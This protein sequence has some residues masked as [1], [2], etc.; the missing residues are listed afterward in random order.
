[1]GIEG[2]NLVN[3]LKWETFRQN[4]AETRDANGRLMEDNSSFF[5]LINKVDYT[6]GLGRLDLQPRFKSELLRQTAFLVAE[7]DREEW[8]ATAQLIATLPVLRT[9]LFRPDWSSCGSA[10]RA[11]MRTRLLPP[12]ASRRRAT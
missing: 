7:D 2:L 3:K 9:R 11:G 5:G 12:V 8:T 10:T 4:Q 6:Y 1:M